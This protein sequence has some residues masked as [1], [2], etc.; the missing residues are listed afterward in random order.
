MTLDDRIRS[1][2][3]ELHEAGA[4]L[5]T[6][7]FPSRRTTL[8]RRAVVGALAA[9]VAVIVLLMVPGVLKQLGIQQVETADQPSDSDGVEPV[10]EPLGPSDPLPG[11]LPRFGGGRAPGGSEGSSKDSRSGGSLPAGTIPQG[12]EIAFNRGWEPP[13]IHLMN[14]DGSD[15]RKLRAGP[16]WSP[17]W[18][19][20]GRFIAFTDNRFEGDIQFMNA[21][22]SGHQ[23]L[24]VRGS[25]PTWSP[26]GERLAFNWECDAQ[27]G[28]TC[29]SP[30]G[31]Q[32]DCPECGIGVVARDG[33]GVRRLGSGI[34]PDWGPDG[35]IIFMDGGSIGGSP[36]WVMNSDG[37]GR[38]RL[39]ID[40]A[41]G[42]KWSRD[43]RRIAYYTRPDGLF[44]ANSD[45]TGIVK[46]AP[47]GYED[48]SWSPD[49]DW[50][51]VTR[52]TDRENFP[53]SCG[54]GNAGPS[55]GACDYN[56]Y[57]RGIDGSA[58]RRLTNSNN[59]FFPAF[60]LRR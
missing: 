29:D 41:I 37:S 53:G 17:E 5:T 52:H 3:L 2:V 36:L 54:G 26:D 23:N 9:I 60:S 22:G 58:E 7:V 39:P 31:S 49:G 43:G 59:D 8:R 6:V 19:P 28:G 55:L 50:L 30:D 45:G 11:S 32:N 44:I 51:A 46:V 35:R 15:V 21:D 33:S 12:F 27:F 1:A 14:A 38:T 16:A 25:F 40:R 34:W 20:D 18:S 4:S 47:A 56:I 42:P 10:P 13:D 48:P 24:R 57:L